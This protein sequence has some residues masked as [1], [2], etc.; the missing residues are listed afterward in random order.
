MHEV[1]SQTQNIIVK[2]TNPIDPTSF[3]SSFVRIVPENYLSVEEQDGG[4]ISFP[5]SDS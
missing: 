1:Y 5:F 2:C 4:W 3:D